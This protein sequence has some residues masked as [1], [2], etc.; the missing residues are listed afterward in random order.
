[1]GYFI[2]GGDEDTSL[3]RGY[4]FTFLGDGTVKVTR[5]G[6]PPVQGSWD[7][8][9]NDTRFELHFGVP[10]LLERLEEDW[11]VDHVYDDEILLHEPGYPFNQFNLE[12]Y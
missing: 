11:V 10:G 2:A 5:P 4:V 6:A 8:S 7:T 12:R 3:F 1:V 9:D